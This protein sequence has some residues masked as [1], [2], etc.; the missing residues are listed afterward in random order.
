[1]STSEFQNK[2]Q[3][4]DADIGW[5][6]CVLAQPKFGV[7]VDPSPTRREDY[8]HRITACPPGFENLTL[9]Q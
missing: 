8:A 5:A 4:S 2:I 3:Y 6:G 9:L 7:S 1:M